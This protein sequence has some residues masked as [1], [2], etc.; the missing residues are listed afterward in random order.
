MALSDARLHLK[1]EKC[2]F[3]KQEVKYRGFIIGTNGIRID[4]ENISC[5]LDWQSPKNVTEVQ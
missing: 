4:L 5:I 2:K 3:H 1:P